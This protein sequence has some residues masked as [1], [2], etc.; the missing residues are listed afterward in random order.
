MIHRLQVFLQA[1]QSSPA[2][3]LAFLTLIFL[4]RFIYT[5]D[6]MAMSSNVGNPQIYESGDQMDHPGKNHKGDRFNEG[7]KNS[8]KSDDSSKFR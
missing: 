6:A 1:S 3:Y 7:K 2:L 8:H 5:P 4:Q